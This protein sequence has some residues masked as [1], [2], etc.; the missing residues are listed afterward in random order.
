MRDSRY[1]HPANALAELIDN[2]IDAHADNVEVLVREEWTDVNGRNRRRISE[3]AVI[4]DGIG[5]SAETLVEAVRFGGRQ[6]T[7][8]IRKIGKYGM[9]LPTA[10][11][12]QCRRFDVWSWQKD[13]ELAVHSYIDLDE[14]EKEG[15]AEIPE[16]T[17]IPVP[18]VWIDLSHFETLDRT[19]GTLVV[20]SKP[21]R[22]G[23]MRAETIFTQVEEE[24]GRIYRH[25]IHNKELGI[26]MAA[27][28]PEGVEPY[29][30]KPV[31]PNDPLYLMP[32]SATPTP[33]DEEP[34]FKPYT[35]REFN[36][37][38]DGKEERV[39]VVYSLVKQE[40]LGGNKNFTPG[41]TLYGR[42]AGKNMGISVIRENREIVL[43]EFF[44]RG[45]M[46]SQGGSAAPENRWWGCEIR[47]NR[48]CDNLFGVDHNKQM[49][50]HLSRALKDLY[51]SESSESQTLE[52]M[53][54]EDDD[55]DI[56]I[57]AQHVKA[58]TRTLLRTELAQ[59]F[60]R[61]PGK[62][63]LNGVDT[64]PNRAAAQVATEAIQEAIDDGEVE[65][66]QTNIDRQEH[67]DD[68]RIEDLTN[69]LVRER[70]EPDAARK[71]ATELVIQGLN[72]N[73]EHSDL[74]GSEMFKVDRSGDILNV[75]LNI[76]HKVYDCIR[77][78]ED[79]AAKNDSIDLRRAA[80]GLEVLLLAWARMED[81]NQ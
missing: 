40:A 65:P 13:I 47:F 44:V 3:L 67:T 36:F 73:F 64:S 63:S 45:G 78:I 37:K 80:I 18:Q 60:D 77:V 15:L 38:V 30:D 17:G 51:E 29:I 11:V 71:K 75:H 26:R 1:R 10:S 39:E 22:I 53:G 74:R 8:S 7:P 56:H 28:R 23:G 52:E 25:Y 41:N 19:R 69:Y 54:I 4:D 61:R 49:V 33:W 48:G 76:N 35:S 50:S 12:S 68:E 16:P 43:E 58:T 57:I 14:I 81:E 79:E 72:Y 21:D 24:I 70:Y 66:S 31:A 55:H 59:M 9:G 62:T 5:M 46:R 6:E 27:V 42:H 20:W 2:S 32:H 34:M